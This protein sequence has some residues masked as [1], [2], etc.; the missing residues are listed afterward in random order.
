MDAG[1]D[2]PVMVAAG[3]LA[4]DPLAVG[5]KVISG[6]GPAPSGSIGTLAAGLDFDDAAAFS[7]ATRACLTAFFPGCSLIS[8][9]LVVATEADV[10]VGVAVP[11]GIS[12][13]EELLKKSLNRA[14]LAIWPVHPATKGRNEVA[15]T[16]N[17]MI[18][19]PVR[20]SSA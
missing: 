5:S 7:G 20:L 2:A 4:T 18:G 16:I 1:A 9:A 6:A 14:T 12:A 13:G 19:W 10:A 17:Q 8:S 3:V 15:P 11:D